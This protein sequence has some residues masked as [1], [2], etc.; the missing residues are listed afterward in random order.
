VKQAGEHVDYTGI[1]INIF[2]PERPF[3][4]C[5]TLSALYVRD[6]TRVVSDLQNSIYSVH[7]PC[8]AHDVARARCCQGGPS[9]SLRVALPRRL[10]SYQQH[11]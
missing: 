8:S 1:M 2:S 6:A 9:L 5:L 3:S 4:S 11:H 7:Q 10:P